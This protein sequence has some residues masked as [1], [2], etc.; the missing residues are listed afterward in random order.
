MR[1]KRELFNNCKGNPRQQKA[2]ALAIYLKRLLGRTSTLHDYT[3]NKLHKI[4][5]LS[6]T[7]IKKYIP[8]LKQ[9]D[10][11]HFTGKNNQH[12]VVSKLSSHTGNRNI[13]I[14][15][16]KFSTT[17]DIYN[18]LRAFLVLAI[19]ARK[20]FVRRTIQTF[21][22]PSSNKEMRSARKT[23]KR[24]VKAGVLKGIDDVYCELGLSYARMARETGNCIRT[25][26][27]VIKFAIANG[28]CKKR[29]NKEVIPLKGIAFRD[30]GEFFTYSTQD[31]LVLM[32]ANIYYLSEGI[33]NSLGMVYIVGKK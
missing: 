12:L 7:T 4:S 13:N 26:Q 23:M 5:G 32:H 30:T 29:V 8:I 24:L 21:S 11:V 27:R 6:P 14:D 20:D 28:W 33:S 25:I 17:K 19:Q 31:T 15:A 16:F 9:M 1:L 2:L 3:V 18:S 10:L 22:H